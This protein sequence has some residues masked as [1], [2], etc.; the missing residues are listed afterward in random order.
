VLLAIGAWRWYVWWNL[1]PYSGA[2]W[3]RQQEGP[4]AEAVFRY[5]IAAHR[6]SQQCFLSLRRQP[7]PGALTAR[8]ASMPFVLPISTRLQD[9]PRGFIDADTKLPALHFWVDGIEWLSDIEADV[10]GGGASG[11]LSGD[12]GT[13]KVRWHR[14]KWSVAS[15]VPKVIH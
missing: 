7:P 11:N 4:V 14:R 9:R 15:Y 10:E 5:Q 8:F 3:R 1:P 12:A 2:E 13:F 6:T